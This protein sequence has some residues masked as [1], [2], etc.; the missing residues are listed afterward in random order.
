ML[1]E[2]AGRTAHSLSFITDGKWQP[3]RPADYDAACQAGRSYAA[4][5]LELMFQTGNA[6]LFG[7]VARAITEAGTFGGVEAGFYA[8][9]GI[10][11]VGA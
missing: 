2:V 3:Q 8:R 1:T 7:S 9:I 10:E 5:L 4:E 11:I 6:M